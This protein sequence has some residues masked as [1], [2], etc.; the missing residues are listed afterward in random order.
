MKEFFDFIR[1]YEWIDWWRFELCVLISLGLAGVV[2]LFVP[3]RGMWFRISS[4]VILVGGISGLVW[5]WR[6]RRTI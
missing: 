6:K 5:Q 1:S 3:D 2:Y 4:G